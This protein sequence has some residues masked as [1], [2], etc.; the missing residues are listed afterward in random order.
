M[1]LIRVAVFLPTASTSPGEGEDNMAQ[2]FRLWLRTFISTASA[3]MRANATDFTSYLRVASLTIA[4]YELSSNFPSASASASK[5]TS[6][7]SID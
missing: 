2:V 4:L 1:P 7:P 3:E 6:S 5:A